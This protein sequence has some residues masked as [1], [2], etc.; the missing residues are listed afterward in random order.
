MG[1]VKKPQTNPRTNQSTMSSSALTMCCCSFTED[2]LED[3]IG[4]KV[5]LF[6]PWFGTDGSEC[7][8]TLRAFHK[9]TGCECH[10]DNLYW[11]TGQCTR[12][13]FEESSYTDCYNHFRKFAAPPLVVLTFERPPP[14]MSLTAAVHCFDMLLLSRAVPDSPGDTHR[15]LNA[16][17]AT[18]FE[19]AIPFLIA[20]RGANPNKLSGYGEYSIGINHVKHTNVAPLVTAVL[21]SQH[22]SIK[23]LLRAA[24]TI[25]VGLALRIACSDLD[26][27]SIG[28]LLD[29]GADPDGDEYSPRTP[30]QNVLQNPRNVARAVAMLLEAGASPTR[31]GLTKAPAPLASAIAHGDLAV[32]TLL[33]RAGASV[34]APTFDGT[35]NFP[36]MHLVGQ[37][38]PAMYR[39]LVKAGAPIDQIWAEFSPLGLSVA[40]RRPDEHVTALIELG[41][42]TANVPVDHVGTYSR[43]L[44]LESNKNTTTFQRVMIGTPVPIMK[45]LL[46]DGIAT[47]TST[48][49]ADLT[50]LAHAFNTSTVAHAF[51]RFAL[52]PWKPIT[53]HLSTKWD[54]KPIALL[55]HIRCRLAH[56]D[57]LFIPPEMWHCICVFI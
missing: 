10:G 52:S 55:M 56:N 8:D 4:T 26:H 1:V 32:V 18:G 49:F 2:E 15:A 44:F 50:R 53:H 45:D 42:D 57:T 9:A 48:T 31:T 54:N 6:T 5:W 19:Q 43:N 30:L 41:A 13:I 27:A 23:A 39:L 21:Q 38:A 7:I 11:H 3:L 40:S 29:A 25:K 12:H 16:A 22:G 17:A 14:V 35:N 36:P 20:Y 34:T 37:A 51:A 46:R 47:T 33:V 28:M 24:P